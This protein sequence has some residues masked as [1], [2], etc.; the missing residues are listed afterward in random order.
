MEGWVA[1]LGALGTLAGVLVGLYLKVLHDKHKLDREKFDAERAA[2]REDMEETTKKKRDDA[3]DKDRELK[4]VV[5]LLRADR[6]SDRDL[7]HQLRNDC[8]TMA[9]KLAV[10]DADRHDL[11]QQ[12]ATLTEACRRGGIQIKPTDRMHLT[13]DLDSEGRPGD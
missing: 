4:Q 10:C 13:P 1:V 8:N 5:E 12:I 3:R 7:I 11:R 6:D 9:M 2:K